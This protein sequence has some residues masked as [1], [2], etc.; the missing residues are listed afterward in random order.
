MQGTRKLVLP[1]HT[2]AE[3]LMFRNLISQ[4]REFNPPNV[5]EPPWNQAVKAWNA[6]VDENDE[7]SGSGLY[8]KVILS[9][10]FTRSQN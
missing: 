5:S 8:Y 4:N 6:S 10:Q 7:T 3:R 2:T 9:E 1:I